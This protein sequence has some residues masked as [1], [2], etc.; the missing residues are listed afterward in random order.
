MRRINSS[1][2]CL[3]QATSQQ[4]SEISLSIGLPWLWRPWTRN[5]LNVDIGESKKKLKELQTSRCTWKPTI[6]DNLVTTVRCLE[7]DGPCIQCNCQKDESPRK[8]L[9]HKPLSSEDQGLAGSRPSNWMQFTAYSWVREHRTLEH[10]SWWL[11]WGN[12]YIALEN[13]TM[14]SFISEVLYGGDIQTLPTFLE[15]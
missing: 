10:S 9:S 14:I 8:R 2:K 15:F 11:R 1:I 12:I 5:Q 13:I 4:C 7:K 3:L 6:R